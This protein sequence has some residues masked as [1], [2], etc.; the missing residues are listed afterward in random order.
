MRMPEA[1]MGDSALRRVL[2]ALSPHRALVVG[3]AVRNALLGQPVEDIDIATDALPERVVDLAR[4]AGLKPVPTGIEHGTITVVADGRGFEV[5]TF[6][7]DV[8]TDGRRAVVDFSDRIEDDAARRDFTMNALY[9]EPSGE[10]LDPVGGLPDL[11]ARRL[12]FVGDPDERITE[13]YL[14]ILRFFRFHA[15]YGRPGAA[16]AKALAACARHAGGLAHI[17]R[18]R[19]GAEMR[20]LLSADNPVE[21][22]QLMEDAG[23]LAQVLQG[24]RAGGLAALC[25]V[26]PDGDAGPGRCPGPRDILTK[27]KDWELRL[28]SLGADDPA[29]ALRLSRAE[30]RV[31]E[32][33]HSGLTLGEAAYRLGAG[34]AGQLALLR[35]SR[36]EALRADWREQIDFAA[37]QVLPISAADLSHRLSGPAL[38][39]GLKAAEAAW[40]E[41]D[42]LMP[43]PALVDIAL[44][45]GEAP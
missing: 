4:A 37:R 31:Q 40:I 17:S 27:K 15:H 45:T 41:S 42:F 25:A 22:V 33:L 23:V 12:R 19:I 16:D 36:G 32:E 20:K 6:R 30:A 34:R 9:A 26:A 29:G 2:A 5:T 8:E 3:G 44:L 24:A 39:R 18:E 35:A 10:V 14:R 11:S 38:G 7:R 13:D 21:A 43:A 1:I 28:A